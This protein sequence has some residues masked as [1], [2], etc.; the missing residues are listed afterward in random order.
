MSGP[1]Q[2]QIDELLEEGCAQRRYIHDLK[3][4]HDRAIT[5]L[6]WLAEGRGRRES[7]TESWTSAMQKLAADELV[8]IAK[9][10][11]REGP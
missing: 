10:P 11:L 3:T 9:L 6:G 2:K 7:I 1:K 8:N 5:V 4:R